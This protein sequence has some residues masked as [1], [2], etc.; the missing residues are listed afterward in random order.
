MTQS[1]H[2]VTF[3]REKLTSSTPKENDSMK[4]YYKENNE[5]LRWEFR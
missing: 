1:E 3:E 5:A 4:I 2:D